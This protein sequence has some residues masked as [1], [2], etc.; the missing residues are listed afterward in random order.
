MKAGIKRIETTLQNLVPQSTTQEIHQGAPSPALSFEINASRQTKTQLEQEVISKVT[1]ISNQNIS[2]PNINIFN[3]HTHESVQAFS[4]E[5]AQ[6]DEWKAP[7]LPKFKT[8]AFTSHR[9]G[10]NPALASNLLCEIQQIVTVWQVELQTVIR[11]IQDV[12]IEGPIVNGWLESQSVQATD[13]TI[14]TAALRHAE[15]DRL[16][17]YVEEICATHGQTKSK[18]SLRTGYRLCGLDAAGKVWSRPCPPEQVANV[19]MAIARYQKLRHLLERKQYLEN[20]L[21]Q[22]S[23][24]LV[25]LHGHLQSP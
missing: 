19:S 16:M 24:T 5:P 15:V 4:V 8:P 23:E 21:S 22:L 11:Q 20:R 3:S 17:D 25:M 12:Y 13:A 6:D 2:N 7:D 9:N 18:E 14:G 10:A 1:D